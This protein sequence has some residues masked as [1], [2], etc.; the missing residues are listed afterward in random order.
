VTLFCGDSNELSIS[1]K[2]EDFLAR[3]AII[4]FSIRI[5]VIAMDVDARFIQYA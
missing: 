2:V 4:G 3:C 5:L 1:I